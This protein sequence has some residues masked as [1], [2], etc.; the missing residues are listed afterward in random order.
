[1][2]DLYAK[3]AA[4]GGL[5]AVDRAYMREASFAHMARLATEAKT[6][7]TNSWIAS[8]FQRRRG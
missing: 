1:M 8:H 6:S 4:D 2:A 3:G 7:G 5:Y